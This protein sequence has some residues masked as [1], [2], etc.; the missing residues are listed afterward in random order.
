MHP[1]CIYTYIHV[2]ALYAC[3]ALYTEIK[4]SISVS[5]CLCL[6]RASSPRVFMIG[7]ESPLSRSC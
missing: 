5:L 7:S 1:I 6:L 3:T 4:G 2:G